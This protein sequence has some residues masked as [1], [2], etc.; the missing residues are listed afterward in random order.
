MFYARYPCVRQTLSYR[1]DGALEKPLTAHERQTP[2]LL[3]SAT[4]MDMG[5]MMEDQGV[6][7]CT[8]GVQKVSD[9]GP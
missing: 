1:V 6:N 9:L 4:L 2:N 3:T 8:R 7:V 5:P